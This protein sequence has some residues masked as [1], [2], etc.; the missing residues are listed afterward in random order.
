MVS[1]AGETK[2]RRSKF[3]EEGTHLS[4]ETASALQTVQIER[5]ITTIGTD[6]IKIGVHTEQITRGPYKITGMRRETASEIHTNP[7]GPEKIDQGTATKDR[8]TEG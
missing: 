5:T 3:S 1:L 8:E 2:Y 7:T 4:A 6:Q